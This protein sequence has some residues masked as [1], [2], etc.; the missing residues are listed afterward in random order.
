MADIERQRNFSIYP[1]RT[2]FFTCTRTSAAKNHQGS[3]EISW[4]L[5]FMYISTQI[6]TWN[7][8]SFQVSL[9]QRY[10]RVSFQG[11]CAHAHMRC[12]D[13]YA[14]V[15]EIHFKK[16]VGVWCAIALLHTFLDKRPEMP[17]FCLINYSRTSLSCFRTSIP[18]WRRLFCFRTSYS[19]IEHPKKC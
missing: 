11:A 15:R 6:L 18:T 1:F 10:Q 13:A 4:L 16:S 2:L 19:V 17:L 8:K 12:L 5:L 3:G 14:G 9:Y 7:Y